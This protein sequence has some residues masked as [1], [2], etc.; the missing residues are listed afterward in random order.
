MQ[1]IL[2]YIENYKKSNPTGW[3]K[4]LIGS[5]VTLLVV[6]LLFVFSLRMKLRSDEIVRLQHEK[7]LLQ[8]EIRSAAVLGEV[9]NLTEKQQKAALAA[10]QAVI[11]VEEINGKLSQLRYTHAENRDLIQSLNTWSDV[12][13]K[14]E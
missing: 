12:D 9:S 14:V 11:R 10:E 4:W 1:K 7:D 8:A 3:R 6:V 2:D 5:V 13:A